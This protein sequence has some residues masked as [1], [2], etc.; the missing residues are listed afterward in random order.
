MTNLNE[1]RQLLGL[2]PSSKE[3]T[4]YLS[5][6]SS[7]QPSSP[8]IKSYPDAVYFNYYSFGLSLLFAPINDYKPQSK[9]SRQ[10]LQDAHPILSLPL[11]SQPRRTLN[12]A[13]PT[14]L[15]SKLHRT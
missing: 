3:L 7:S 1:L 2:S 6:I 11:P 9:A 4:T 14:R 12:R 13:R 10:D 15:F 8:E 5:A